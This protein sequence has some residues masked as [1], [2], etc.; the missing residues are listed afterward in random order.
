MAVEIITQSITDCM[1]GKKDGGKGKESNK[2][3]EGRRGFSIDFP[4]IELP[5]LDLPGFAWPSINEPGLP[6]IIAG[7]IGANLAGI[8]YVL[9]F[10]PPTPD[11]LPSPP[12]I[13]IFVEG[14]FASA[15]GM[16]SFEAASISVPGIGS[17][18]IPSFSGKTPSN[19][20][21]DPSPILSLIALFIGVPFLII[22]GIV[23]DLATLQIKIPDIEGIMGYFYSAGAGLGIPK[24][25]LEI[26]VPC[27]AKGILEVFTSL[28]P[29]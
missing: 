9:G 4:D 25:S 6:T 15:P 26:C 7:C 18:P 5:D 8:N 11:N 1:S 10:L 23:T 14:F 27:I 13:G 28:L 20:G 2:K 22:K 24:A 3:K 12:S 29:I 16:P 19:P 17:I 21:F